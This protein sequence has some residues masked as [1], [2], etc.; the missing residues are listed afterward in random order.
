MGGAGRHPRRRPP[1]RNAV[2]ASLLHRVGLDDFVA[3]GHDAYVDAAVCARPATP[4]GSHS[5]APGPGRERFA[6]LAAVATRPG[7]A[8][9]PLEAAYRA[10]VGAPGAAVRAQGRIR[11]MEGSVC[12]ARHRGAFNLAAFHRGRETSSSPAGAAWPKPRRSTGKPRRSRRTTPEGAARGLGL[13]NWRRG[14]LVAADDPDRRPPSPPIRRRPPYHDHHGLV[15]AALGP[16]HSGGG[17]RIAAPSRSIPRP[18]G[19]IQ[20][21]R[22]TCCA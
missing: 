13:V 2:G 10:I 21:P 12:D 17:G 15:L 18:R 14:A 4:R 11:L 22:E 20:Q 1:C 16:Q 3:T 9:G 19:G 7:F 8:R 6:R 5:C